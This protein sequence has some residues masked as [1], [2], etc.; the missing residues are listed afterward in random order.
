MVI[1][2]GSLQSN[3]YFNALLQPMYNNFYSI[4]GFRYT[5]DCPS[6]FTQALYDCELVLFKAEVDSAFIE[7]NDL[8]FEGDADSLQGACV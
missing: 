6:N 5:E 4:V 1:G 7:A 2:L 8:I 3:S